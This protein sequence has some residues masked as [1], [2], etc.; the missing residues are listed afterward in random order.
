AIDTDG[1]T[2]MSPE[3][4]FVIDAVA[5]RRI[6]VRGALFTAR[7]QPGDQLVRALDAVAER[8][9]ALPA[10]A[11]VA[12]TVDVAAVRNASAASARLAVAV[13]SAAIARHLAD[14]GVGEGRVDVQA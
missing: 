2:A 14:R 3:R 11:P 13:R 9:L 10:G 12:I 8:I 4:A 7:G 1:A 5:G 6:E